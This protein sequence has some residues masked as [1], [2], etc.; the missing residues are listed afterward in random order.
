MGL[1]LDDGEDVGVR[2]TEGRGILEGLP[3]GEGEGLL[4]GE[5]VGVR[6][7]VP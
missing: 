7:G 6:D 5:C 2:V 4:E 1:T 3:E